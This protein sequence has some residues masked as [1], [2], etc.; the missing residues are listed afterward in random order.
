MN[1]QGGPL[2]G[3][4][5]VEAA[6]YVTGPYAGLLLSDLGAEVVKIEDPRGGDP[7]RGWGRGDGYGSTFIA[8]NRGKRSVTLNLQHPKGLAAARKLIAGADVFIEN[9]RPGVAER[10]GIGHAAMA[11]ANPRLVYCSITGLGR[12]GPYAERPAFDIVGQGL[13]GLLSLFVEPDDPRPMGPTLSDTLTGLFAAYGIL[14]A[15]QGRERTGRGQ[16]VETSLLQA[17]M[18]FMHEPFAS[19]FGSGKASDAFDRPRASQ[20][21][22]FVCGD[23]RPIAI[24]LSSPVKFWEAFVTAAGHPEFIADPRFA[25]HADRRRNHHLVQ[26]GLAPAFRGR[27]RAEWMEI[28]AAHEVPFAPIYKVD[29]ALDDPQVRHLGMIHTAHHPEKGDVRLVGFPVTLNGTPLGPLTA[30]ATL[31]EHTREVLA[32]IGCDADEIEEMRAAGAA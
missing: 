14:A 26:E 29:E 23:G 16:L 25:S 21:Y 7:F 4:R 32:E 28:L 18:G 5:V 8:F 22:A 3:C 12:D 20:V 27:S 19:Y 9:F 2:A 11:A 15:L 1:G 31:G 6:R 13:S 17:T 30:P 10:L 24:H